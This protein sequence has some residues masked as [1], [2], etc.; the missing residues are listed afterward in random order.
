MR[1]VPPLLLLLS[2]TGT[3]APVSGPPGAAPPEDR[4]G[5]DVDPGKPDEERPADPPPERPSE[6]DP[7]DF[8]T[9][10]EAITASTIPASGLGEG[11]L[12]AASTGDGGAV[13]A[14][15]GAGGV[16]LTRVDES[17]NAGGDLATVDGVAPWGLAVAGDGD[18]GVL[19]SRGSDSLALA[20]VDA[21]GAPRFDKSLL[22]AGGEGGVFGPY[23]EQGRL[24][25]T[26]A[27]WVAYYTVH[28]GGHYG[29]RLRHFDA[30]GARVDDGWDWGCSHSMDMRIVHNGRTLGPV[31]VSDCYPERA[32]L[33]NHYDNLFSDPTGDCGGGTS[34]ALGDVVP[35]SDGFWVAFLTSYSRSSDDVGLVHVSDGGAGGPVAWLTTDSVE[36]GDVHLAPFGDGLLAG[37]VASG[38][39]TMQR[40]DGSGA[41]AAEP[42]QVSSASLQGASDFLLYPNGDVG[43]VSPAGGGLKMARLRACD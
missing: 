4:P 11:Q 25:W 24:T 33:F 35:W 5:Q 20:V 1:L 29:D 37:W 13:V 32:L 17:G 6:P 12:F 10:D 36:D 15:G 31:C 16:H 43:W 9:L 27:S 14:W 2:C 26:G 42:E 19:V 34:T 23:I 18:V 21:S 28:E 39:T 3:I 40:L 22:G 41:P 8:A 38:R 7:C 30:T